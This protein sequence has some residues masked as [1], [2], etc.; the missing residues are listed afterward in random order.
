[1]KDLRHENLNPFIGACVEPQR[2]CI[3]S[4]YCTRG[5][6]KDILNNDDV[7]LDNMFIASLIFDIIRGIIYLHDSY[8]GFHGNL[9]A[10]NCL[11]DSRWVLRLADFGLQGFKSDWPDLT[12][13]LGKPEPNV[14]EDLCE[15]LLYRAPELLRS[16]QGRMKFCNFKKNGKI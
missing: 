14:D 12:Q 5:S 16:N 2:I 3:V 1:M 8:I 10:S 13:I 9:K 7:T 6:L 4:E 15:S 11:V